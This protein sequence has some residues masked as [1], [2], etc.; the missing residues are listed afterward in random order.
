[1]KTENLKKETIELF[2]NIPELKQFIELCGEK[3]REFLKRQ[4][5]K[6][7]QGWERY[8]EAERAATDYFNNRNSNKTF[9]RAT[10]NQMQME[11]FKIRPKFAE[12]KEET[13]ERMVESWKVNESNMIAERL[14]IEFGNITGTHLHVGVDG[15]VNGTIIGTLKKA[16]IESIFA[17]GYNIQRLHT[18]MLIHEI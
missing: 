6:V 14:T 5:E 12:W 2:N 3:Q 10:Y 1:M 18:R 15:N 13:I 17:G 8:Y 4:N 7:K 11:A 9:S 16:R